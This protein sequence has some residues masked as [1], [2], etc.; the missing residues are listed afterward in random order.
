M[1]AKKARLKKYKSGS[2]LKKIQA[3]ISVSPRTLKELHRLAA[4]HD[5]TLSAYLAYKGLDKQEVIK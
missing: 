2:R 1:E 4:G 5:M 3:S